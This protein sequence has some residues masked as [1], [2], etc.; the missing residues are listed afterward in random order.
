MRMRVPL[1]A[2]EEP[3]PSARALAAADWGNGI[4]MI[5]PIDRFLFINVD[6]QVFLLRRPDDAW[7]RLD[8]VTRVGPAAVGLAES[9]LWDRR[10]R[11]GSGRQTLFVAPR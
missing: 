6:L 3:S 1:V 2:G 9:V 7:V 4:S 11:I 5:L 10:G 8:A